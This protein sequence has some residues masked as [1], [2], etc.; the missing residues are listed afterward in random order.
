MLHRGEEAHRAIRIVAGARGDADADRVGFEFLRAREARQRELRFGERQRAGFRIADHVGDDAAD[1]VG[2]LRLLLAD[3][4]VA[5]DDVAHLVRQHGGKLGFVVGERDQAARHV[6]L[7][8][9][10]REGVDRLR[11]EH[12]DFVMQVGPLRRRDQPL[13]RL[14]DHA[15]QRGIVI[16]AAI[17]RQDALMLA[18]HRRRHG[19]VGRLR[20][21]RQRRL[22]RDGG[23]RGGAGGE[24]QRRHGDARMGK[25]KLAVPDRPANHGHRVNRPITRDRASRSAPDAPP[26][27]MG[28]PPRRPRA[29][30]YSRGPARA[31]RRAPSD[32]APPPRNCARFASG[33]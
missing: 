7:A 27:S 1:Q 14:L 4:G 17:G 2:L 22:R 18:Q 9:R 31:G 5:R 33:S 28:C 30:R 13:D 21:R 24:Q 11:I 3:R 29:P 20:R 15:L 23:R 12:R 6:K 10:Q 32:R 19:G 26:R 16:D 8:G 25:P